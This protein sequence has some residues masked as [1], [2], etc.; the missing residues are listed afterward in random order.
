MKSRKLWD[1]L[2]LTR[3]TMYKPESIAYWL[4]EQPKEF[5]D[6]IAHELMEPAVNIRAWI[7]LLQQ[8]PAITSLP[9]EK[10]SEV[11]VQKVL[12]FILENATTVDDIARLLR[13]YA[14]T[15]AFT[16]PPTEP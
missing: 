8:D 12:E 3:E 10:G 9:I 7:E 1:E 16:E 5:L 2:G 13:Q 15:A 11:T 14:R 6:G 4:Q